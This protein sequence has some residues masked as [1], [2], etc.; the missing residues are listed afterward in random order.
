[1]SW[2]ATRCC[3]PPPSQRSCRCPGPR[4][5]PT[6]TYRAERRKDGAACRRRPDLNRSLAARRVRRA[7]RTS[8]SVL[9]RRQPR[10]GGGGAVAADPRPLAGPAVLDEQAWGSVRR[11]YDPRGG[12]RSS[13]QPDLGGKP[14]QRPFALPAVAPT[15][16]R[17]DSRRPLTPVVAD[18]EDLGVLQLRLHP[19][20]GL[21]RLGDLSSTPRPCPSA[22]A[23]GFCAGGGVGEA[24]DQ[25]DPGRHHRGPSRCCLPDRLAAAG[26][27]GLK[28]AVQPE[29]RD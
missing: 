18:E 12:R 2:R 16:R 23:C 25:P 6:C 19:W 20:Q 10:A 22:S 28:P 14:P 26:Q 9:R 7:H 15:L 17:G 1:M 21:P 4:P 5:S 8:P 11:T 3:P 24:A 27:G 13:G 29:V